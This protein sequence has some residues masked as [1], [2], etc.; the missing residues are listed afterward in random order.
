VPNPAH[1][2]SVMRV[3]VPGS[4]VIKVTLYDV[5]GRAGKPLARVADAAGSFDVALA[6]LASLGA[7]LYFYRVECGT[8]SA[9]GRFVLTR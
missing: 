5:R 1:G 6:D 3:H 2:Q 9:A 8:Q 7:A 4:G